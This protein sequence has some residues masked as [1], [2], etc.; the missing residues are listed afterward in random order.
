MGAGAGCADVILL[1]ALRWLFRASVV[2]LVVVVAS[3]PLFWPP[4]DQRGVWQTEGFGL[5]LDIDR[6]RFTAYHLSEGYCLPYFSALSHSLVLGETEDLSFD[7]D[8]DSLRLTVQGT[9]GTVNAE[10]LT[11]LPEACTPQTPPA[12]A[13]AQ[14]VFDVFWAAMNAHYPYFDLHGVAWEERRAHLPPDAGDDDLWQAMTAA[15][16]GL[17]DAGLF[18]FD[19]TRLFTPAPAQDWWQHVPDYVDVIAARGL[20]QVPDTGLAYAVLPDNIGYVFLRHMGT[21]TGLFTAPEEVAYRA[22][23]SVS[24]ALRSTRAIVLDNRLNPGGAQ[25][26]ALAYASFF[27]TTPAPAFTLQTRTAQGYTAPLEGAARAFGTLQQP[28][29]LLNSSRTAGAAELFT[30]AMKDLPQVT[31][32]GE[33]TQGA[34]AAVLDLRLPN[35]WVMGLPNQKVLDA[36]GQDHTAAGIPPDQ[37]EPFAWQAFDQGHDPQLDAVLQRLP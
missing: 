29:Y 27:T 10:R 20:T 35:G 34:L 16:S 30:L 26:V 32:L 31:L 14:Q 19:G 8:G 6:F 1:G 21:N 17:D 23:E 7:L 18:V 11:A 28:V 3:W 15:L 33:P 37:A 22:F 24:D 36:Q 9:L 4:Q 5:V 13:S 25:T 12:H 2:A